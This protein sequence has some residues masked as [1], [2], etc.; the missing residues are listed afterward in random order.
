MLRITLAVGLVLAS[1]K[2]AEST[3]PAVS[4]VGKSKLNTI[5]IHLF[6]SFFFISIF[7]N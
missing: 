6:Q 2:G 5:G 7:E 4:T 1:L 3:W